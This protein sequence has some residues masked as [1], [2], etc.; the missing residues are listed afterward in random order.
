M[1][2]GKAIKSKAQ[3]AYLMIHNPKVGHKLAHETSK[4]NMKNLPKYAKRKK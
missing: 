3:L 1:P 2:K 4:K